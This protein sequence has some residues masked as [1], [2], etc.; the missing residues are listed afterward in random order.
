VADKALKSLILLLS[1]TKCSSSKINN[2]K[3]QTSLARTDAKGFSGA[4]TNL[5]PPAPGFP[6]ADHAPDQ[7]SSTWLL[8]Q[9]GFTCI[10]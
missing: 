4:L 8:T 2:L 5:Q 7:G 9:F 10:T 1:P 6:D 3:L